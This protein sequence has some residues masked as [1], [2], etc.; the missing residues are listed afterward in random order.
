MPLVISCGGNSGS[1]AATLVTRA[2]ALAEITPKD[3]LRIVRREVIAA[4]LLG[5]MLGALGFGC[6]ALFTHT[7]VASTGFPFML[8]LTV[9]LSITG[10]V[11][12]GTLLGSLLP[13]L[14]KRF[15]VDPAVASSPM[16]ATLMD[17]SG[18]LIYLGAAIAL[19]TG[20]LL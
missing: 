12:W 9:A 1:Q 6:A 16:V 4:M 14:L 11:L 3:W 10:V 13:L 19:L 2:L 5:T 18:T 8:S 17:A 20:K 15:G 7:S